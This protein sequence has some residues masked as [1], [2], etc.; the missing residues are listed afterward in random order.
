MLEENLRTR[1]KP[2]FYHNKK[3]IG[4]MFVLPALIYMLLLIGYPI[5]Y[6]IILSFQNVTAMTLSQGKHAFIGWDNF[7]EIF[8][9]PAFIPS[10]CHTFIYTL[11]SIVFQFILGF[12]LALFFNEEFS[13]AKPIS[14]LIVISWILPVTVTALTWKFMLGT[15]NGIIN[16]I[17]LHLHIINKP[18]SWLIGS[19][20]ALW[21]LILAN[22]WIGIPFNMLLLTT[23]LANIPPSIYEAANIDGASIFQRFRKITLPLLKP[24]MMSVLVLGVIY[25]FKVFDLVYVM[26][27]GGPVNSTEV[28]STYSYKLSF[29]FYRFGQGAAAANVLFVILLF[30]AL[31]YLR[32]ITKEEDI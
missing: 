21:G 28:I 1:Y 13:F 7:K 6:N 32:T 19:T 23:G 5:I 4:Y 31:M 29:R 17:L 14:G 24:T 2:K 8:A 10:V 15:D 9:D 18:I 20:T 12:L 16:T 25:T 11:G 27:D 3:F 26:T 30:I 22:S